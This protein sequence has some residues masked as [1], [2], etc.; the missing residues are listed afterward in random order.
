MLHN[1]CAL[2]RRQ[3]MSCKRNAKAVR[4]HL[5]ADHNDTPLFLCTALNT[6]A[7]TTLMHM[8]YCQVMSCK[9]NAKAVRAYLGVASSDTPLYGAD[10]LMQRAVRRVG[11]PDAVDTYLTT[12]EEFQQVNLWLFKIGQKSKC[13]GLPFFRD[14]CFS[15]Q[16]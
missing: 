11:S 4:A 15:Q 8:P 12:I 6:Y 16:V 10:T 3:V 13:F 9:R 14:C 5:A 1:A 2:P 7:A